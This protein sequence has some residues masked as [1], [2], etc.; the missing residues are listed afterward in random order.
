MK[1]ILA[2][3][4]LLVSG[5]LVSTVAHADCT[6]NPFQMG[7]DAARQACDDIAQM[8]VPVYQAPAGP[9]PET[10]CSLE[11]VVQ[12]KNAMAQFLRVH[13]ACGNLIAQNVPLTDPSTGASRGNAAS[14]WRAYVTTTCNLR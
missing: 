2:N 3:A 9:T 12:C 1:T 11:D 14:I 13:P 4:T 7:Y 8:Y 6:S 10:T 5:L